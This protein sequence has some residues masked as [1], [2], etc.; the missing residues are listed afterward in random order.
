ML[1]WGWYCVQSCK[2]AGPLHYKLC[3]A[4]CMALVTAWCTYQCL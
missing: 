2:A 3:M 1:R 4:G